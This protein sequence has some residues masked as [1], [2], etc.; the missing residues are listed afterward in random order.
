MNEQIQRRFAALVIDFFLI[1]IV[2][3]VLL[4]LL[5]ENLMQ[6]RTTGLELNFAMSP[7]EFF[8][9]SFLYFVG[10]DLCNGG[11]SLGKDIFGLETRT[12]DGAIPGIRSRVYRTV[13]KM[14]SLVFWPLALFFFFW[15]ERYLTLQD[16]MV[17]SVVKSSG[18]PVTAP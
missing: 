11:N 3:S 6:F 15:K 14:M 9:L 7:D 13:F 17:G 4:N 10:C 1:S 18:G 8:L 2:Y 16:Y 12:I 5:S